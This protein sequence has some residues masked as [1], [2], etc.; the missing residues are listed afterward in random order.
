MSTA[1]REIQHRIGTARKIHKV[2]RALQR[3]SAARLGRDRL[4]IAASQ[5]YTKRMIQA[6]WRV[7][8]AAP[9]A[10][11]PFLK[12]RKPVRRAAVAVF[13]ADR[14]LCGGFNSELLMELQTLSVEHPSTELDLILVGNVLVRRIHRLGMKPV[15]SYPQPRSAERGDVVRDISERIMSGFS[16][17]RVDAVYLIYSWFRAGLRHESVVEQVLPAPFTTT[18]NRRPA[19]FEPTPQAVLDQLLPGFVR[20]SVDHAF[21]NSVGAENAARQSAMSRAARNAEEMTS[22]L[23]VRYS[24]LRQEN[25]TTEMLELAAGGR[26]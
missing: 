15:V 2:T 6:L 26:T 17:G 5:L 1:L 8:E 11:H 22:E 23:M 19:E 21:L 7:R 18:N 4:T 12:V 25:I 14:G 3:V 10:E 9:G 20:A 24:R 16:S 13:G